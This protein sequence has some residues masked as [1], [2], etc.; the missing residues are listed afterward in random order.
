MSGSALYASE[1][2]QYK[3]VEPSFPISKS[4]VKVSS[5]LAEELKVKLQNRDDDVEKLKFLSTHPQFDTVMVDADGDDP[6]GFYKYFLCSS[7]AEK[8]KMNLDNIFYATNI[9]GSYPWTDYKKFII[10]LF[11]TK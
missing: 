6:L 2:L 9:I 3:K 4:F 11:L 8:T 5:A 7:E 1:F 10:D